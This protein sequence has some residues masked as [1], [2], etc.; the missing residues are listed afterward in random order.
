M[1]NKY[2]A[3]KT[4]LHYT[5]MQVLNRSIPPHLKK[6]KLPDF[7]IPEKTVLDNKIPVFSID[8]GPSSTIKMEFIIKA[9]SRYSRKQLISK[10]TAGLLQE[11]TY[12]YTAEQIAQKLDYFG[13]YLEFSYGK[14]AVYLKLLVLKRYL[15]EIMPLMAELIWAPVFPDEELQI[16][17]VNSRQQF[18]VNEK[19]VRILAKRHFFP[20][21]FGS[22]HPYG[23]VVKPHHF[24][25]IQRQDLLNFYNDRYHPDNFKIIITGDVDKNIVSLFNKYFGKH[26]RKNQVESDKWPLQELPEPQRIVLE[27]PDAL[28][29]AIRIG[30]VL[31]NKNHPDY[32]KSQI[33]NTI[34]GGY[35]GSRLMTN[36]REDKGYTYGIGSGISSFYESGYFFISSE[37]GSE[38]SRFALTEIYAELEKLLQEKVPDNELVLVKNYLKGDLLRQ[39][40]GLFSLSESYKRII[41]YDLDVDFFRN[42][43]NTISDITA[44]DII[45]IAQ[46]HFTKESLTELVVGKK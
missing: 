14:D 30:K 20:L 36:I 46:K 17:K 29:S 16:Y 9:G 7:I 21:V 33:F 3:S 40:D 4:V 26:A 15:P 27:K 31:F 44:E 12:Y 11:G 32:L 19:R 43:F 39:L 28:Q 10:F 25:E 34:F 2:S 37:V 24:S 41:E 22:Q 45:S 23:K 1:Q 5:I 38:V 42:Y 6:I 35:F 18:Q 13:T 8:A